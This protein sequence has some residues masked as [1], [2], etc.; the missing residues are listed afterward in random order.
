MRNR[1]NRNDTALTIDLAPMVDVVFLLIIFFMVST[2]FINIEQS[3]PIQLPQAQSS[4]AITS[5]M[6]TVTVDANNQIFVSGQ[7]VQL[8]QLAAIVRQQIESKQIRDVVYRADKIVPH[9]LSV[10][11]MD[12]IR[13]A[14][15]KQILIATGGG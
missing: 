10:Q 4:R 13:Q 11:V 6:P 15:A 2:T 8:S 7:K 9:G 12:K 14:G 1:R 5:D 3:M